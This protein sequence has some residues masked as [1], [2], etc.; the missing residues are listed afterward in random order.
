MNQRILKFIL[1][2]TNDDL[3]D[4]E[5]TEKYW[6]DFKILFPTNGLLETHNEMI[7]D[8]K[9]LLGN[10]KALEVCYETSICT[11]R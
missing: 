4:T 3:R 10:F 1:D 9:Q 8:V 5:N 6:I 11:T 7:K 2:L